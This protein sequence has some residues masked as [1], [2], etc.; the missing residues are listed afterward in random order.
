MGTGCDGRV[1]LELGYHGGGTALHGILR[2]VWGPGSV[3]PTGDS[4]RPRDRA[5]KL[6]PGHRMQDISSAQNPVAWN[7]SIEQAHDDVH[8]ELILGFVAC[9][10]F[11]LH[12]C[13]TKKE[14]CLFY[15]C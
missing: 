3:R 4:A 14:I 10:N 7:T 9:F 11:V 12:F 1:G 6:L 8:T 13:L 15:T 2:G 5:E